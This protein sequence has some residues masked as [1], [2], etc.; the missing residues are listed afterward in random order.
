[1]F[2]FSFFLNDTSYNATPP[3][4]DQPNPVDGH[5]DFMAG[6]SE[7]SSFGDDQKN[8]TTA[9]YNWDF[10]RPKYQCV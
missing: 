4:P 10:S 5:D 3:A 1:M 9:T 8:S 7:D 2:F 6:L